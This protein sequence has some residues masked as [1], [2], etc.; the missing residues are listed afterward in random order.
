MDMVSATAAPP[1]CDARTGVL[2]GTHGFDPLWCGTRVGLTSYTDR[3]G[4]VRHYCRHHGALVRHRFQPAPPIRQ[5]CAICKRPVIEE[6]AISINVGA[7]IGVVCH[8]CQERGD[9][10]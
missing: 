10:R 9:D 5:G 1:T 2:P 8:V 7:H 6:L 4:T 3:T